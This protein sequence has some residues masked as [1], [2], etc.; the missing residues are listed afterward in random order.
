MTTLV[1]H[2]IFTTLME[3]AKVCSLGEMSRALYQVGGQ[4]RRNM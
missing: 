4:Y 3:A 2:N 1:N